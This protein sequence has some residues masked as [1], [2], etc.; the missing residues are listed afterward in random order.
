MSTRISRTSKASTRPAFFKVLAAVTVV[1]AAGGA[2]AIWASGSGKAGAGMQTADIT[3]ASVTSFDI[4]TVA[5]GELAA[6]QQVELRNRLERVG[7]IVEIIKEGTRVEQGEVLL[8]F[9]TEEIQSKIDE[10]LLQVESAKNEASAAES[11]YR[12]QVS[13]NDNALRNAELDLELAQLALQQWLN[14]DDIKKQ[15]ELDVE[16]ENRRRQL[17]RLREKYERSTELEAQ[18]FLSTD[19]WKLDGINLAEAEA[20]YEIAQLD[21]ESYIQYQRPKEMKSRESDVLNAEEEVKRVLE[22]NEINLQNKAADRASEQRRYQL[23]QDQLEKLQ[24]ELENA[25]ITAPTAGLVV[26]ATSLDTGGWRGNNEGPL[27]VGRQLRPN[28]L[29]IVLPDT[30]EMVASVRVH[31][32]LAGRI[33]PG[34]KANITVDAARGTTFSGSVESVG[35]LAESGGWRDPNRREYTVR[36]KINDPDPILKPSM[37]CE[38]ELVLGE[39]DETLTVPVQSIFSE[40]S[41]RYVYRPAGA[42]YER[43]PVRVGRRSAMHAEVLA[44]IDAGDEV[45]LREPTPGEVISVEWTEEQLAALGGRQGGYPAGMTR[46]AAGQGRSGWSGGQRPQ[47]GG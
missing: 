40:G 10:A 4:T 8:K 23:R 38:A 11:S 13:E 20:A 24:R 26:Y 31:E 46:P 35:V 34:Q 44:G 29:A 28:E 19:E 22:Q 39:V 36:L 2:T 43:V 33:R 16:I 30:S 18:G 41:V 21:K 42:K 37:R 17:D 47:Q 3:E 27:Q 5:T 9:N 15:K 25:T 7:T 1:A 14:G 45:L 32:S 12:I 6:R